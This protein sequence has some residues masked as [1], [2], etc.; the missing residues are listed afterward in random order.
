[1]IRPRT[2]RCHE[3]TSI[4]LWSGSC[5]T[6]YL[7]YL[8]LSTFLQRLILT[9]FFAQNFHCLVLRFDKLPSLHANSISSYFMAATY[10]N[11]AESLGGK[12]D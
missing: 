8:T 4:L 9:Q 12:M 3:D 2:G 1:M 11:T 6:D 5:T 10:K 7:R